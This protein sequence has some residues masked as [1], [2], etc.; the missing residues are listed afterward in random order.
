M[1]NFLKKLAILCLILPIFTGCANHATGSIS[2]TTDLKS[3]KTMY[4][5]KYPSDNSDVDLQI[6]DK[7]RTK[8]VKVT[9]GA[10]EVPP[11]NFDAIVSYVDRWMWDITMYMIELT[12]TIRDPKNNELLATGNSMHTSLTRKSQLAM[13]DEVVNNIYNPPGTATTTPATTVASANTE[14]AVPQKLRE[15]QTLKNDGLISE[16]EYQDK[17]EK[18]LKQY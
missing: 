12:V 4:V 16:N 13:I 5:K 11:G 9:T 3:L 8:G 15:L 10:E 14:S 18:L 17:R 1:S 2:A 6:A 7:L